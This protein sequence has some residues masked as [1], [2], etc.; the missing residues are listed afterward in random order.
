[1]TIQTA[2]DY[3]QS[4]RMSIKF[5]TCNTVV[6]CQDGCRLSDIYIQ[7]ASQNTTAKVAEKS[8][9]SNLDC[10]QIEIS[11]SNLMQF[12]CKI[13][14]VAFYVFCITFNVFIKTYC[15]RYKSIGCSY[16]NKIIACSI[17][18]C[19]QNGA[20]NGCSIISASKVF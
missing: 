7:L 19:R 8:Y 4:F 5:Q 14:N 18:G 17:V 16:T 10:I 20:S 15:Q 1:M 11:A 6:Y 12:H 9:P 13:G 3:Q 2:T